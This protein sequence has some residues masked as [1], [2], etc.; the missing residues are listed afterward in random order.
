MRPR[1]PAAGCPGGF[2]ML[3]LVSQRRSS[4]LDARP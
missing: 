3:S 1:F 4:R 2:A